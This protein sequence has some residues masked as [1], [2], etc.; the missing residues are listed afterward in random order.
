MLNEQEGLFINCF[1]TRFV[2]RE[3]TSHC[4]VECWFMVTS[5]N[6][7]PVCAAYM[8]AIKRT[9][10]VYQTEAKAM[11]SQGNRDKAH[12]L[13]NKKNLVERE[14]SQLTIYSLPPEVKSTHHLFPSTR[15]QL[16]IY[17]LPPEVN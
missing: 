10:A 14:A 6:W 9:K 1:M 12:I 15:S 5:V 17:F 11:V 3:I 16:T 8:E 7:S 2:F 4:V 13:L